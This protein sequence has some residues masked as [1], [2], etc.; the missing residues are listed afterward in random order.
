MA[1]LISIFLIFISYTA[2]ANNHQN[3]K[4]SDL[5]NIIQ[6]SSY[7]SLILSMAKLKAKRL[8]VSLV[9]IIEYG[10]SSR[11]DT[12]YLRKISSSKLGP[13]I[14][15]EKK[16]KITLNQKNSTIYAALDLVHE[17]THFLYKNEQ[18]P[19]SEK[20]VMKKYIKDAIEG[21]GG[22]IE[23]YIS[24]CRVAK[25]IN[26]FKNKD[27][28]KGI[29]EGSSRARFRL[30]RQYYE[31]GDHYYAFINELGPRFNHREFRFISKKQSQFVSS[32][33]ELPYPLAMLRQFKSLK[34]R[35]C[36]NNRS[37][38]QRRLASLL[39]DDPEC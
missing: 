32:V 16:F 14:E 6:K 21:P 4:T 7:G 2:I 37:L 36:E 10:S 34:K 8:G 24:E 17:L 33:W 18:N 22:E 12:N 15:Y 28:C 26:V 13:K 35:V 3:I 30:T 31:L 39:I 9:D 11:M 29:D 23:A 5:F 20:F 25:E 27:L 38:K 19:Y 1:K